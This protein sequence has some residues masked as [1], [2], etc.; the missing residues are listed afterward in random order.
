MYGRDS[1]IPV[2]FPG[3]RFRLS[4]LLE[5][6][7]TPEYRDF[8]GLSKLAFLIKFSSSVNVL[9]INYY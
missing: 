6:S 8:G 9:S 4:G 2:Q 7:L 1:E 3:Y 5:D